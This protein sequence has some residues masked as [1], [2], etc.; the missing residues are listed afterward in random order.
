MAMGAPGQSAE[1]LSRRRIAV[2][3]PRDWRRRYILHPDPHAVVAE[4]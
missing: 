3:V 2:V 1:R 4:V